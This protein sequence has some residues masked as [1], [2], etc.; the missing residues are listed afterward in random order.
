LAAI[1]NKQ[2]G[3]SVEHTRQVLAQGFGLTVCRAFVC[4]ALAR[5]AHRAAPTYGA[6][7]VAV[8][9]SPVAALDETGCRAGGLLQWLH[10]ALTALG[11]CCAPLRPVLLDDL[12]LPEHP[13]STGPPP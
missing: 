11:H 3:L 8:R 7:V 2:M 1:L 10:V 13:A 6:L 12:L 5:L 9:Q 4:R